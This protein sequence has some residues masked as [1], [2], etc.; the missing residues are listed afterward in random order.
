MPWTPS[1]ESGIPPGSQAAQAPP[2]AAA[3]NADE[4]IR[5]PAF[6]ARVEMRRVAGHPQELELEREHD[7]VER[8]ARAGPRRHVVESVEEAG[9]RRE[10]LLVRLLLGEEAEHRLEPDHADLEPVRVGTD[11]VVRADERGARDG[12]ELP[13]PLVEHELDVGEGLETRAEA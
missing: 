1:G 12:L 7:G 3:R 6:D 4:R 8:S 9:Q 5:R 2:P 13:T 10:R 11:P